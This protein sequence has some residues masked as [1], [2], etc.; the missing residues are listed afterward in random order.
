MPTL[1]IRLSPTFKVGKYKYIDAKNILNYV[2][3]TLGEVG[4]FLLI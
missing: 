4:I 3:P 1:K 2:F